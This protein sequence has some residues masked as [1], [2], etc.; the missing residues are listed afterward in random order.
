M[1][2][3]EIQHGFVQRPTHRNNPY[4]AAMF[5]VCG[6]RYAD[7]SEGNYGVSLL[8]DC[9]YGHS[10]TGSTLCLS[11]LRSSKSPDPDC[12]MGIHTFRYGV[13]PHLGGTIHQGKVAKAAANFNVNHLFFRP[14]D[15]LQ[16]EHMREDSPIPSGFLLGGVVKTIP[17]DCGLVVDVLKVSEDGS[18]IILRVAEVEGTRGVATVSLAFPY[19]TSATLIDLNEGECI[20]ATKPSLFCTQTD[21]GFNVQINYT[22]FEIVSVRLQ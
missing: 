3:Y 13:F 5:E 15:S 12:D 6:H 20:T 21:Y 10:C 4:D 1:A 14:D 9:K 11:L 7:L 8:N 2:T 19:I 16:E 17:S 18:A 22:P